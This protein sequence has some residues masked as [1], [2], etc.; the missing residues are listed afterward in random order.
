M[1]ALSFKKFFSFVSYF[2]R[3]GLF[4]RDICSWDH[5]LEYISRHLSSSF[6][7][8]LFS[9][10][11]LRGFVS[12]EG[13]R[14]SWIL[15]TVNSN[16]FQP[17]TH[18]FSQNRNSMKTYFFI[19]L[20]KGWMAIFKLFCYLTVAIDVKSYRKMIFFG[21]LALGFCFKK[22]KVA[23]NSNCS[24]TTNLKFKIWALQTCWPLRAPQTSKKC[25]H[26]AGFPYLKVKRFDS[27]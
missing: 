19:V 15:A 16:V 5:N 22:W 11:F 21:N 3:Q 1:E 17:G 14:I 18:C 23:A 13:S 8:F 25:S 4:L 7:L 9:C 10:L 26:A 12:R 2:G 24:R 6:K 20:I 27:F